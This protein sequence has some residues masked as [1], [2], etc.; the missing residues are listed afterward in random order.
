M[1]LER[2]EVSISQKQPCL[3]I[4]LAFA[5]LHTQRISFLLEKTAELGVDLLIPF[6]SFYTQIKNI[7]SAKIVHWQNIVTEAVR[8]SERLWLPEI[9]PVQKWQDIVSLAKGY[10]QA[11][12]LDKEGVNFTNLQFKEAENLL[13]IVG[14]EGGFS[15]HEKKQLKSENI[16]FAKLS[17]SVL[18]AETAAVLAVGLM[19]ILA[20]NDI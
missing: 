6:V 8:Q 10:K 3:K 19:R 9:M 4:A 17:V 7:P 18:R 2:K 5:V 11:L 1:V 14:P 15:Q 12:V 16:T 13:L 20:D